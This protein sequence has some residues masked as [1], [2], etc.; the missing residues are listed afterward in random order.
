[1][2]KK[3]KPVQVEQ[4]KLSVAIVKQF[5]KDSLPLSKKISSLSIE[6]EHD[7]ETAA[8][9]LKK[10]KANAKAAIK[11]RQ[12]MT[13]PLKTVIKRIE[14]HFKPFIDSIALIEK[15]TKAKMDQFLKENTKKEAKVI[16]MFGTGQ[17]ST[18]QFLKQ[19]K[20]LTV[21]SSNA[22]V[23]TV[24]KLVITRSSLIPRE[25]LIPE[26]SLI[27][28]ALKSGKKVPGCKLVDTNQIAV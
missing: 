27:E 12:S 4:D 26:E 25:Y 15:D 2:K 1:M 6:S 18:K 21:T 28:Q 7:Y 17:I 9:L 19:T 16:Q 8:E 24:K 20:A 5:Q 3:T 23:R 14:K 22:K 11:E 13:G 10:L